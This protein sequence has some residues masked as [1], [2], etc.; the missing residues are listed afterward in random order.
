MRIKR[1]KQQFIRCS[2]KD[3]IDK[4]K[5]L[6]FQLVEEKNNVAVFINDMSKKM[7]FDKSKIAYSNIMTMS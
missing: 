3:T 2:D 7:D 4:L 6:G 1:M 5:K